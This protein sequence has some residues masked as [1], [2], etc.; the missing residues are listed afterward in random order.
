LFANARDLVVANIDKREDSQRV[1]TH[2]FSENLAIWPKTSR[3]LPSGNHPAE[4]RE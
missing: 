3:I 1:A 4:K 2:P